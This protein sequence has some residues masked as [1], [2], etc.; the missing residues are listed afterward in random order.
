MKYGLLLSILVISLSS[1]QKKASCSQELELGANS[2][3]PTVG[4]KLELTASQGV[5]NDVYYWDGP[6]L[7]EI[8]NSN[9]ITI[10]EIKLSQSGTYYV[11]RNSGECNNTLHD[12]IVIDVKL[13]QETPPCSLTN[14]RADCSNIPDVNFT[15]VYQTFNTSFNGVSLEGYGP[16]GYPGTF[17]VLFNSY[18][19]NVEPKDGTYNTT[20]GS[21]F[22]ILN[23]PNDISVSFIYA[24][25][26]YHC[27]PNQKVYITHLN[28]K[29]RASLCNMTF[30][31]P[32]LPFTTVSA[33]LTEL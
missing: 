4:Q 6:G 11:S 32:P 17:V 10:D 31:S 28:G 25:N 29:L 18:N 1:C 21:V 5:E 19:G 16:S 8:T 33:Q 14:N 9:K 3:T 26:Y 24:S 30:S 7:H 15:S 2:A 12:S 23:E 13:L 20:N 27:H 22:S